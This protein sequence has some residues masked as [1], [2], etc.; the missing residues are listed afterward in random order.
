MEYLCLKLC[1][2][3]THR[4]YFRLAVVYWWTTL[5]YNSYFPCHFYSYHYYMTFYEFSLLLSYGFFCFFEPDGGYFTKRDSDGIF[6]SSARSYQGKSS[7][8]FL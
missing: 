7:L 4:F 6:A 2:Q 5:I 8:L 1:P 3:L